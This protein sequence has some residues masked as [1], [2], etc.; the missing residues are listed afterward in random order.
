MTAD[1]DALHALAGQLRSGQAVVARSTVT[2]S[3][4][5]PPTTPETYVKQAP[6]IEN[7]GTPSLVSISSIPSRP[8]PSRPALTDA[9]PRLKGSQAQLDVSQ[10]D[11][12]RLR[13][14]HSAKIITYV[15]RKLA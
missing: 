4:T 10:C 7:G 15:Y 14:V 5:S 6:L 1:Q 12:L 2:P 8:I 9:G 13:L 11:S 3:L